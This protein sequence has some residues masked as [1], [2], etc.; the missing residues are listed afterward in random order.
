MLLWKLVHWSLLKVLP[1]AENEGGI[2]Q[3]ALW[4][5]AFA[6]SFPIIMIY[7]VPG[8]IL[9]YFFLRAI[10]NIEEIGHCVLS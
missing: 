7:R 9:L 2:L 1:S 10:Y 8:R 4:N 5:D 6:T 3:P